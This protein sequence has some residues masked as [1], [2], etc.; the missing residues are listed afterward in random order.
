MIGLA[1]AL[2]RK[3]I[4]QAF[5]WLTASLAHILAAA[6]AVA[7]L[8]GWYG[9]HEAA[10]YHRAYDSAT[11]ALNAVPDA[12]KAALQAQ[13][14]LNA[15]TVAKYAQHAKEADNAKDDALAAANAAYAAS[16]RLRAACDNRATSQAIATPADSPASRGDGPGEGAI[17]VSAADFATLT[18][19]TDRLLRVKAW[20]D[21]LVSAGMG[22]VVK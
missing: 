18:E 17:V 9:H 13:Q 11:R 8:W 3:Q 15:A 4:M 14:D 6:L 22:E 20:G 12:Q 19:N 2:C 21:G 7:L 10:K 16:H 5:G 1:L